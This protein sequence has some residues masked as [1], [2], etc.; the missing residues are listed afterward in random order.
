MAVLEERVAY[1]EGQMEQ[2]GRLFSTMRED[3]VDIR[4]R[5]ARLDD[6]VSSQFLWLV[7][8]QITTF[9]ITIGALLS[10]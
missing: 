4:Q 1:L 2:F 5:L 10:R 9:A 7:G 6:K 8:V 3:I